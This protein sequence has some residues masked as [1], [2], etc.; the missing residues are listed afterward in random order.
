MRVPPWRGRVTVATGKEVN[1]GTPGEVDAV[2]RARPARS[3]HAARVRGTRARP[4]DRP[5][6][7]RLRARRRARARARRSG[8]RR[9][10]ARHRG[11]RPQ[12]HHQGRAHGGEGDEG[13]DPSPPR[14]ARDELRA[15]LRAPDGDRQRAPDRD[16]REG[17]AHAA[18][19]EDGSGEAAPDRDRGR[20]RRLARG[21]CPPATATGRPPAGALA[22]PGVDELVVVRRSR[23]RKRWS[24]TVPWGG[25]V[26]LTVPERMA[27][28][29]I[30]RV[31]ESHREW[32]AGMRAGQVPRL[33]L[34]PRAV[35][36]AE[37]R[38][39]ARELVTMVAE[40][41]ATALG[42][43]YERIAIRGQRTRWGSCSSRGTLSF[44]WRLALAPFAVLD[45][46]VVHE[47][48]HLREHN[49]SGHFWAL[50]AERRPG[51]RGPRDWLREHGEELLAFHP[52]P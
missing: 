35:S 44:N 15:E 6:D 4:R 52:L 48:C 32:I 5:A 31:L 23:K 46:V 12:A 24:L 11:D 37:A 16:L 2:G 18:R 1:H 19:P 30:E 45:Y 27:R 25:P 14:A 33:G 13:E 43:A 50:V 21:W 26:T 20:L 49:H 10:G 39:A 8:L 22:F 40:E 41:E 42:V 28:A 34:D 9:A 38:R 29:E 3:P 47:L 17:R 51:W 7:G 36:E